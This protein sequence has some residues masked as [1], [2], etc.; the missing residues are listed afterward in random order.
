MEITRPYG[1][2]KRPTYDELVQY[3]QRDNGEF[4]VKAP[5]RSATILETM[6]PYLSAWKQTQQAMM[7]K[8]QAELALWSSDGKQGDAPLPVREGEEGWANIPTE[9]NQMVDGHQN[10][11]A[12]QRISEWQR[13]A[14]GMH[15][16]ASNDQARQHDEASL[17]DWWQGMAPDPDIHRAMHEGIDLEPH[18][19]PPAIP[20]STAQSLHDAIVGSAHTGAVAGVAG[21]SA[22]LGRDMA[23]TGL[24]GMSE[25]PVVSGGAIGRL[26]GRQAG[27]LSLWENAAV[28]VGEVG[29]ERA[30][31]LGLAT[32]G[33]GLELAGLGVLGAGTLPLVGAV[34][35]ALGVAALTGAALGVGQGGVHWLSDQTS[36]AA[37]NIGAFFHQGR[38]V[39]ARP[40]PTDHTSL[41]MV[42]ALGPE[43]MIQGDPT[44]QSSTYDHLRQVTGPHHGDVPRFPG[45]MT[46]PSMPMPRRPHGIGRG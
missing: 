30:G 32:V 1:L 7:K 34:G 16:A 15:V 13:H 37:H 3:I 20:P 27:S 9:I 10:A 23:M 8:K 43:R 33:E 4:L 29:L 6:S 22:L 14:A 19:P 36:A 46:G 44:A 40:R 2:H 41:N 18:V 45:G 31:A 26:V 11:M 12:A 42:E 35:G 25:G 21:R 38:G 17:A 39:D 24:R 5:D 28:N